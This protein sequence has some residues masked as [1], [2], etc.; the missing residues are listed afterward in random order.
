MS[1]WKKIAFEEFFSSNGKKK[2]QQTRLSSAKKRETSLFSQ[3]ALF[4]IEDHSANMK[5]SLTQRTKQYAAYSYFRVCVRRVWAGSISQ[6]LQ[7]NVVVR[8]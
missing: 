5:Y 3:E 8:V 4:I 6:H 2:S 7:T 1:P